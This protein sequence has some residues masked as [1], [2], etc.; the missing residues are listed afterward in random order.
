MSETRP[1]AERGTGTRKGRRFLAWYYNRMAPKTEAAGLAWR[2]EQLLAGAAGDV[3]EIGAGTGLN[4][5]HYPST[6]DRLHLFEPD[7]HMAAYLRPRLPGHAA[8]GDATAD[9]LPLEDA[10]VAAAVTTLVLCSV[11]DVEAA[12][13]EIRRVLRPGGKLFFLEHVRAQDPGLARRQDRWDGIWSRCAGG[14]HLNRD[15]VTGIE[16]AGFAIRRLDRFEIPIPVKV[17]RPA[18]SGVA[19]R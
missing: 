18:V 3:V 19:I 13:T 5:E 11:P 9:S 7:P 16:R 1:K 8:L 14:C 12:L 10:S 17:T 6:V 15:T 2:R 4:L